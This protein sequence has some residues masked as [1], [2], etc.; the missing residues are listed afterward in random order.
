MARRRAR[1]NGL[2]L[3]EVVLSASI[4]AGVVALVLTGYARMASA[5]L[6]ARERSEAAALLEIKLHEIYALSDLTLLE[7]QG[8]FA[9]VEDFGTPLADAAWQIEVTSIESGLS[10][11]DVTVTW[12]GGRG[13]D[14]VKASTLKFLPSELQAQS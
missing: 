14:A 6:A 4:M 8:D 7:L 13:E 11:V 9:D 1:S 2:T 3:L 10:R 5:A 12:R